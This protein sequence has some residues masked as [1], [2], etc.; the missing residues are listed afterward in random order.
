MC[1]FAYAFLF[2]ILFISAVFIRSV[3]FI[4]VLR[5][6]L[7]LQCDCICMT[8]RAFTQ[9]FLHRQSILTGCFEEIERLFRN[10]VLH[11]SV[12]AEMRSPF[13]FCLQKFSDEYD[14]S[15]EYIS[16]VLINYLISY[17]FS[18][19]YS[20]LYFILGGGLCQTEVFL[21]EKP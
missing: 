2:S 20:L 7:V 21:D 11:N 16:Y 3:V 6:I 18:L 9:I 5:L 10:F 15:L 12:F 8:L 14:I 13:F 17:F 4:R 1:L 19:S